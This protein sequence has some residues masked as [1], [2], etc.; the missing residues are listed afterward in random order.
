MSPIH[1]IEVFQGATPGLLQG[2]FCLV[3]VP[4]KA[5]EELIERSL[6]ALQQRF[7]GMA[8]AL[9]KLGDQFAVLIGCRSRHPAP[10]ILSFRCASRIHYLNRPGKW[11]KRVFP[12]AAGGRFDGAL[13]GIGTA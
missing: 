7:Q 2:V 11:G 3:M 9:A 12:P 13:P 4:E 5:N 6:V 1:A 10:P 8:I